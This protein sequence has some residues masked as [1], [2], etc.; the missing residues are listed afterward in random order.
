MVETS[1]VVKDNS[2]AEQKESWKAMKSAE[3]LATWRAERTAAV[4]AEKWV[5]WLVVLMAVLWDD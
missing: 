1:V 4:T 2:L 3:H 5:D